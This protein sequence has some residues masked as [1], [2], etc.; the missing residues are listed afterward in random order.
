MFLRSRQVPDELDLGPACT[1]R[2]TLPRSVSTDRGSYTDDA[3]KESS[4]ASERTQFYSA[5]CSES[6]F[7]LP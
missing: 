1:A 5:S 6:R 3:G 7:S 4:A 2:I